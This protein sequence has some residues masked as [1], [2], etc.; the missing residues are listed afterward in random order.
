MLANRKLHTAV[1]QAGARGQRREKG[2]EEEEEKSI[3]EEEGRGDWEFRKGGT[4][5]AC[6]SSGQPLARVRLLCLQSLWHHVLLPMVQRL[7]LLK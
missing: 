7:Q 2:Q 3:S 6:C 1:L 5:G 4:E